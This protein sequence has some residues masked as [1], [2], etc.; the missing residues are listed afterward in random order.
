M[1]FPEQIL[2]LTTIKDA[3]IYAEGF[4]RALRALTYPNSHLSIGMLEGD[5]N[6][7]TY[8]VFA[9]ILPEL[10]HRFR[11]A[12]LWKKDFGFKI[13][14][15]VRRSA[16]HIQVER[17]TTLAKARNHLL[18]HALDDEDWVL[19]L[20]VDIIEYPPD[21]L[22]TLLR[23]GKQIV[24]PHCVRRHGGPTFDRNAWRARGRLHL[25]D[26]R[27]EGELVNL[28]SVGGTMLLVR[29]D[30]HRDGLVFPAF[31]YGIG[32]PKIRT[33]NF[34]YGELETEGLGIMADDMGLQCWGL[35]RVEIIHHAL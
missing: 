31:P 3:A 28:D 26:L 10:T 7:R 34:W 1:P 25:E 23:T 33:D 9:G 16:N 2:I 15:G 8:E 20:D 13:P 6:D 27:S 18:F 30:V 35:P 17:R 22:E 19:W 14:S 24:Q 5:S 4:V 21:I 11:R 12:E 29:A 32:N